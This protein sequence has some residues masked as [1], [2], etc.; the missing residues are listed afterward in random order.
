[1]KNE[2]GLGLVVNAPPLA[3]SKNIYFFDIYGSSL[4]RSGNFILHTSYF[5]LQ[6]DCR[7]LNS[8]MNN[9]ENPRRMKESLHRFKGAKV[10]AVLMAILLDV[11]S[12]IGFPLLAGQLVTLSKA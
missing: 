10:L 2:V 6:F 1:M 5:Y 8:C 9:T 4:Y 7:F 11:P 3:V 12:Y